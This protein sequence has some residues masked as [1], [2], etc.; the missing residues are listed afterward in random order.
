MNREKRQSGFTLIELMIVVAII[1]ILAAIA[2]PAYQDFT[3]R[4]QITEG[5]NLAEEIKISAGDFW[6]ARGRTPNG[7]TAN[8][9]GVSATIADLQGTYVQSIDLTNST[10]NLPDAGFRIDV[11]FG[12]Q[13]NQAIAG[14]VVTVAATSNP[15][16]SLVWVCGRA[17]PPSAGIGAPAAGDG[18]TVDNR[19][20]PT[21]CRP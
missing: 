14:Q 12:N 8:S 5:L 21:A 2:I 19:F 18:T 1:G 6:S 13:A 16:G 3:I 11:T 4:T 9:I 10:V 7:V 17:N 20:L 15:A